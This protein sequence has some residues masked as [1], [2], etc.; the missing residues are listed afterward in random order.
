MYNF[1][2]KKTLSYVEVLTCVSVKFKFEASV[3]LS[4]LLRYLFISN[5][6]SN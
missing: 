1:K 2:T 6:D 5:V 3:A 4:E